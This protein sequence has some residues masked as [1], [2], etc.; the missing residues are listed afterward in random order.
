MTGPAADEVLT[1]QGKRYRLWNG[2]ILLDWRNRR[3]LRHPEGCR[4]CC[5]EHTTHA[6]PP[7]HPVNCANCGPAYPGP[8]PD[9]CALCRISTAHF[10][11]DHG[12][13]VHKACL[14]QAITAATQT[15][16]EGHA[17]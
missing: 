16:R 2:Q 3:T 6:G 11:D 13:P 10:R 1:Y 8:R 15:E 5:T 9:L 7:R 12:R 4:L 14:E 17:A